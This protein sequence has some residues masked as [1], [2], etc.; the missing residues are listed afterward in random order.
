MLLHA[1]MYV[2]TRSE[3]L[4]LTAHKAFFVL[5]PVGVEVAAV[6]AILVTAPPL[7]PFSPCCHI[8]HLIPP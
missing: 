8:V 5:C 7:S 4:T 1:S 3:Y 6:G 2:V